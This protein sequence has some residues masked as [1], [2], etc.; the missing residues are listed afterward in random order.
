MTAG[1]AL[2]IRRAGPADL[3]GLL[4][5]ERHFPSD[6]MSRASMRRLLC[7][8]TARIWVAETPAP[9]TLAGALVLLTRARS[10][11][12]RIYSVVV[13]PRVRGRGLGRRLIETA[14]HAARRQGLAAISLEVREDNAAARALYAGLGYQVQCAMAAYY[15]DG[16]GGLRLR[17]SL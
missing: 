17:K 3:D 11:I 12:A 15:E 1:P 16:V 13:D 8:P 6:R 7:S 4:E 10:S 5:L 9:R 2:R 14:E